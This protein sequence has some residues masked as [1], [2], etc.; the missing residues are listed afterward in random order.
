MPKLT[1]IRSLPGAGKTTLAIK[2]AK[3][4]NG[5]A[6]SADDFFTHEDGSYKWTGKLIAA[7]HQYCLGTAF[8]HLSRGKDVF[9]HNVFASKWTIEQYVD[10][11][12]GNGYEWD[13]VEPTT[14]WKN[15]VAECVKHNTHGLTEASIQRMKD[16]WES[17][18]D[19]MKS[20]EKYKAE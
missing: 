19:L 20:F 6:V 10:F 16:S 2:L 18:K 17:T 7:A 12:H 1:L 8:Y 5:V 11:A 15:D 13:I 14:K 4:K 3:E 9:V